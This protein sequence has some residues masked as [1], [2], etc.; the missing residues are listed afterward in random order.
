MASE[1]LESV[2]EDNDEG[3]GRS[4][5]VGGNIF[6]EPPSSSMLASNLLS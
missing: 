1:V 6:L 3:P 5:E 2:D 4:E